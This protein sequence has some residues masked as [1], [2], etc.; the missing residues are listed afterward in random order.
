MRKQVSHRTRLE[1]YLSGN[2]SVGVP[3]ALWRHFPVDDQAPE[4]LAAAHIDFQKAYDFDLL[5]VTPASSY[6][7][8]GWG[9][10]DEWRGI[11][12]GTRDYTHRVIQNE[13]DWVHL[14][15]ISPDR[16][17]LGESLAALRVITRELGPD[18]PV[19][20]TIF[21]PLSQA[22]NLVGREDL[23]VHLRRYPDALHAGLKTICE[24]T[25][26]YI[27]AARETGIAGI[28]YAVQHAQFGLL[29]RQEY[30]EFGRVYDLPV[31][32]AAQELWLNLLHLHG[33][34]VMFDD[35]IDYPVAII[36]WHDQ[37]TPPSLAEGKK[38]FSRLVCGGLQRERNIVLG[39]PDEITRLARQAFIE[40]D[41]E[42][43]LLG[44]GCVVP[45]T[46][47]RANILAARRSVD[48]F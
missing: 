9:V 21:S 30:A 35:F 38:R 11:V 29:S 18:V 20:Q 23:I 19:I 13:Q 3:V 7:A 40:T 42:R 28:F 24:S 41:G 15:V 14:Q 44:T 27:E 48:L 37:D 2:T 33:E 8:K 12:E 1:S 22:K 25:I 6:F 31:L 36:N 47:P 39:S 43:L 46:A 26:R 4:T 17:S 32:E 34:Q 5:K 16:G 45:I 10:R